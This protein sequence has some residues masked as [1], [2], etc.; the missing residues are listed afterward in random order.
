MINQFRPI[1]LCTV[2][3]KIITK[4]I[5]NRLRFKPVVWL[6][7][8]SSLVLFQEGRFR[9]ILLSPR[10]LIFHS[11]R[12]KEGKVGFMVIKVDLEKAYDR[13]RWDFLYDT[14]LEVG[15]PFH[16]VRIIMDCV[17]SS[18]MSILWNGSK[19]DMFYPSRG[20]RQG[21]SKQGLIYSLHSNST[22]RGREVLLGLR[23]RKTYFTLAFDLEPAYLTDGL[24]LPTSMPMPTSMSTEMPIDTGPGPTSKEKKVQLLEL[25]IDLS[26]AT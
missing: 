1:S 15:L 6:L 2:M 8:V 21:D 17:T 7:G 11:M 14:L 26:L 13:I 18:S 12:K 23:T 20:V 4:L 22:L 19:T 25:L 9:I 3:Y 16:F 5:A 10:K 24:A